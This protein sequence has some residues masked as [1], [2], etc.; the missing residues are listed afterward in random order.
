MK[1]QVTL[2]LLLFCYLAAT[3]QKNPTKP[4]LRIYEDNDAFDVTEKATDWGYTNGL[5]LDIFYTP[6]K[7]HAGLFNVFDKLVGEN[8]VTTAGWGVMQSMMVPKGT[9][10]LIP[11]KNDYAYAGGLFAVHTI[12]STNNTKK[13]AVQSEFVAGLLGPLSF[14]KETQILFHTLIKDQLP[15]G[16]GHQLPTDILLNYNLKVEKQLVACKEVALIGGGETFLGSMSDGISMSLLLSSEGKAGHFSGLTNQFFS[17]NRRKPKLSAAVKS[18]V[19]L[20]MYDAL[21]KGGLFNKNSPVYN[22]DCESGTDLKRQKLRYNLELFLLASFRGF[23]ISFSQK[24]SSTDFKDYGHHT[25][26]NISIYT[27]L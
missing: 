23:S 16:W 17:V 11:D 5:R 2:L 19:D 6:K 27:T 3:A 25:V 4:F 1:K 8:R 10:L 9:R 14:A 15:Q 18:S 21:L 20:I 22:K 12:H 7:Y 24:A 26:G 13:I